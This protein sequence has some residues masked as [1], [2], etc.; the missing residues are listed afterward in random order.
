MLPLL[1]L[2]AADIHLKYILWSASAWGSVTFHPWA[3]Y[4]LRSVRSVA[5]RVGD[6]PT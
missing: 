4:V 6:C 2:V 3:M 1:F 5:K